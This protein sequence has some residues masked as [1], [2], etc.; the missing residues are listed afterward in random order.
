MQ[1]LDRQKIIVALLLLWLALT[2]SYAGWGNPI[3]LFINFLLWLVL[4]IWL[5]IRA[6]HQDMIGWAIISLMTATILSA[7]LTQHWYVGLTQAAILSGYL[8]IYLL[9][10]Q[11]LDEEAIHQG[12]FLCLIIYMIL[13]TIPWENTS[14]LAFNLIG[15]AWLA[16][17]IGG[18]WML[19]T[20]A[21]FN[22]AYL[23]SIGCYLAIMGGAIVMWRS[24]PGLRLAAVGS[25]V[26]L[27][28]IDW[29]MM[30]DAAFAFRVRFWADALNMFLASPL[31]GIGPG[32][33]RSLVY[34]HAVYWHAH[35]LILTTAAELGLLGLVALGGIILAIWKRWAM[36]PIWAAALTM[37][38]AIWSLVDEPTKF[39]GPGAMLMIAWSKMR[40]Q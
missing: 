10:R 5:C 27:L 1:N 23:G 28:L 37:A 4:M 16:W 6:P 11:W 14:I 18:W 12:A 33:Y 25:V 36:F 15:L 31:W 21:I 39:W 20:I 32:A 7:G 24:R 8:A 29:L 40:V 26:P 19:L 13:S 22:M 3:I 17:P 9:A 30:G 34:W 35:N 38:F 2:G